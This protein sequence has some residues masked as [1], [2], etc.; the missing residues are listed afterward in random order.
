M[1]LRDASLPWLLLLALL[2]STIRVNARRVLPSEHLTNEVVTSVLDKHRRLAS[3]NVPLP[4]S[5]DDHEVKSL[6]LMAEGT[7]TTKHWAGLLP[8][9]PDNDKYFFY[10]LFAPEVSGDVAEADIPL[11]IWLNGGP[12]CSSLGG[13]L[14]ENGPFRPL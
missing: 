13:L 9:S 6:P 7:L 10:W 14:T 1:M 8:A 12:G 3:V 4:S 5:P 11:V 2:V